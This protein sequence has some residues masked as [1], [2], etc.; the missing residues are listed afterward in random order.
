[1]EAAASSVE[2]IKSAFADVTLVPLPRAGYTLYSSSTLLVLT[3]GNGV[4]GFT[5]D[6]LV[7]LRQ[8]LRD[9]V[10]RPCVCSCGVDL[11]LDLRLFKVPSEWAVQRSVA[12]KWRRCRA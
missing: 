6:P 9:A 8:A 12:T 2:G 10:A 11:T 3:I 5:F 4:H 1:M 7:R